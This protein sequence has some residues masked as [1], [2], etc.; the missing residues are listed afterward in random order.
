VLLY[1][2]GDMVAGDLR[3]SAFNS[4]EAETGRTDVLNRLGPPL[5]AFPAG[6]FP[7]GTLPGY[8]YP[9]PDRVVP[10]GGASVYVADQR[11]VVCYV[12]FDADD[13][14]TDVLIE[15]YY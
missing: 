11:C 13:R 5:Q 10:A 8:G 6:P 7:T 12:F 2:V 9:F 15:G 14:V 3:V 1:A 4:L